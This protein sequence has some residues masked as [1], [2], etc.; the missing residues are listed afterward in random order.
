MCFGSREKDDSGLAHSR[1]LDRIIRQDGKRMSKE[2]KLLLLGQYRDPQS[3]RPIDYDG[4]VCGS[5][6]TTPIAMLV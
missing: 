4:R 2:I 6:A 3:S 5:L 1:E